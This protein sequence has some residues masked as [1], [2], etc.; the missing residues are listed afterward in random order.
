MIKIEKTLDEAKKY[1]DKE[2]RMYPVQTRLKI[3]KLYKK[4][5]IELIK[6]YKAEL[7]IFGESK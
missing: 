5:A 7:E 6:C 4:T 2:L 1:F 3:L